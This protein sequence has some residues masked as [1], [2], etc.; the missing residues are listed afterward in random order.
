MKILYSSSAFGVVHDEYAQQR[1]IIELA[2]VDKKN[3]LGLCT[4]LS[5]WKF[6]HDDSFVFIY[7]ARV[8]N[9]LDDALFR[10]M[11]EL[12]HCDSDSTLCGSSSNTGTNSDTHGKVNVN[13]DINNELKREQCINV[14]C[15]IL[16][17]TSLFL[18]HCASKGEYAS[19]DVSG[20]KM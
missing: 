17:W 13:V 11:D 20:A 9:C 16:D 19:S 7:W 8:F 1:G 2:A 10:C 15:C 3:I 4:V 14:V 12:A 6:K 18:Q 5:S